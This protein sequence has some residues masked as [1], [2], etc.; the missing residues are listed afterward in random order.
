MMYSIYDL[1]RPDAHAGVSQSTYCTRTGSRLAV[2]SVR[3]GRSVGHDLES[4]VNDGM[5][6]IRCGV[7]FSKQSL[8]IAR[9]K[10]TYS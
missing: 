8:Q 1:R 4:V 9:S 10:I 5:L 6:V 3:S 2:R 7:R